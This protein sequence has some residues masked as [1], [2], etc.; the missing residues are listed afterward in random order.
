MKDIKSLYETAKSSGKQEDLFAYTEAVEELLESKP[1]D[2]LSNLEYIISSTIGLSRLNEFVEK[3]GL[4]IAV[5][6][7]I[8][9]CLESCVKKC[10]SQKKDASLYE[11]YLEK[12]QAF[13][14]QYSNCFAMF[15]SEKDRDLSLFGT[16]FNKDK[17][18]NTYYGFN[19]NG[20]Q[21]N[22]LLV[23]MINEFGTIAIP[24]L[25]ITSQRIGG[26]ALDQTF[27]YLESYDP[28]FVDIPSTRSKFYINQWI[29]EC[30]I[31]VA[32]DIKDVSSL[33]SIVE[34]SLSAMVDNIEEQQQTLYR[35]SVIMGNAEAEIEYTAE[36]VEAIKDLIS[37]REYQVAAA[38]TPENA[39][40][41]QQQVYDLYEK[42]A[43]VLEE[44][45]ADS[46]I[47]MLPQSGG[48]GPAKDFE[49]DMSLMNTT[50]KKNGK[51]PG[52]LSQNHDL[53][54][55][56]DDGSSKSDDGDKSLEDYERQSVKNGDD[57]SSIGSSFD[58]DDS[59]DSTSSDQA[60]LTPDDK[61]A[62]NNYYY[63]TYN[64]SF[65]KNHNS[66]NRTDSHDVDNS[67]DNSRRNDDHSTGK[68]INSH[69]DN[70]DDHHEES[71]ISDLLNLDIP[72]GKN[73]FF[74]ETGE[75][76]DMKPESDHP[77]KDI[78]QDMD[79][80]LTK[81]QQETKR[82]V[83]NVQNVGRAA[84]KPVK[85]TASWVN[86]MVSKWRDADENKIKERMADP[87]ARKNLFTAVKEAIKIGSL[88]KAGLLL[89]P[90]FLFLSV[91]K[92]IN[93]NKNTE[94]IRAEMIGELKT[95]L[96]V[97]DEKI[98]DAD[99]KDNAAKYK[100]IRLRNEI[101]KKLVRVG[102]SIPNKRWF[103]QSDLARGKL[104]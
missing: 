23:G 94:R 59:D 26:K 24:D 84:V 104:L 40:K 38:D 91:T 43:G 98:K 3:Y 54:W 30:A 77:V 27:K 60:N 47:P 81:A 69:N 44:D 4:S 79:R 46:V 11:E 14:D 90:I 39:S 99:G 71:A 67:V 70:T 101:N 31:D 42:F 36:A 63:Y 50:N 86:G 33:R 41:Y 53:N 52:Y 51:A 1:T 28:V 16:E 7:D 5:Y 37:F 32:D 8:V 34:G 20:I 100:L 22:K 15:E 102:G 56:E 73:S 95:E 45:V 29:A 25:L 68:H 92:K 76:D 9:A 88:A 72:G 58:D 49:E 57:S 78:L 13:K 93:T 35:E 75:A 21:N 2:F 55:G 61:K 64:D 18:V 97:I 87:H 12:Y 62:I 19:E 85:R 10:K 96:E 82:K 80:S 6:D 48:V 66:H 103:K 74:V 83:Q 65:N 17:Y 89:N